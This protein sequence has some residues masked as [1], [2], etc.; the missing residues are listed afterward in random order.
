MVLPEK[1]IRGAHLRMRLLQLQLHDSWDYFT[2]YSIHSQVSFEIW[3][4][5]LWWEDQQHIQT[6]PPI[7]EFD[8][9]SLLFTNALGHGWTIHLDNPPG[10]QHMVS[11]G[12]SATH[13]L[14]G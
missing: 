13:Q 10:F 11:S 12:Q 2:E 4:D 7:H 3:A 5:L 6:G 9:D 14:A 1:I 8:P